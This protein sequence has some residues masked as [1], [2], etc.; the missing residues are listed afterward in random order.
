[1][2]N[3]SNLSMVVGSKPVVLACPS[4]GGNVFGVSLLGVFLVPLIVLLIYLSFRVDGW[5]SKAL[6]YLALG[7]ALLSV[8]ISIVLFSVVSEVLT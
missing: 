1:M 4:V 5:R 8:V 7:L 3:L 6:Y 2:L